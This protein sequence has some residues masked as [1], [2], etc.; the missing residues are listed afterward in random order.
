MM[1]LILSRAIQLPLV[2]L[3]VY[4]ITLVLA[5]AVPGNPLERPEGR[6]PD[7]QVAEAMKARYNLDSFPAFYASYLADAT[8][9]SAIKSR[10]MGTRRPDYFFDLGPS[11]LYPDRNVNEIL[12]TSLPISAS[13]G[14]LAISIAMFTGVGAG[15]VAAWRPGSTA[16]TLTLALSL[17]GVSLPTFV[18]GSALQMV[19][20][21]HLQ[22]L[23]IGEWGHPR[24]FILPAWTLS[25]P[26][27]AYIAGLTRLGLIEQMQS[28]HIRTARAKGLPEHL[29]LLRHALPNAMLPVIT[30]LGPATAAAMTGSFVVERV[31]S[32]P[33]GMGQHFVNAVQNKDLFLIIGVVLLF[34]S[35]LLVL[36][37]S[38]DVISRWIDPRTRSGESLA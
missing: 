8:G 19:F 25:L 4:T 28:D 26:F 34:S 21:V 14:L 35:L 13:L 32:V 20:S 30:Y 23:P 17:L 6:R 18:I 31:F 37:T 36:N 27:A 7:P 2:L 38:V 29:V 5:W 22:W 12:A 24:D 1:R 10:L 9:V 33:G 11:L 16:D 3:A 15:F